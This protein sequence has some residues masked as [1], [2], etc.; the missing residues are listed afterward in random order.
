[1]ELTFDRGTI[2]VKGDIQVPNS[3][4]DE[5]SKAFRTMALQY[6]DIIDFLKLS[7]FDFTDNVLDLIPCPELQS[8]VVLRDYQKKP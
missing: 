6:R 7:A 2:L 3:T 4:W 5:R 8:S 1:M